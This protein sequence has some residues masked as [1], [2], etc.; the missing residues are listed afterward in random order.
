MQHNAYRI[1]TAEEASSMNVPDVEW[2]IEG[3]LPLGFKAILSG[4]TGSNKSYASM[5]LGMRVASA[6]ED[7]SSEFLSYR[8]PKPLKVLYIDIEVGQDE[9]LRRFQRL[10]KSIEFVR[11]ENFVMISLEG[12][13][14][15]AWSTI[16]DATVKLKP[17]LLIID[18]LYSS[19]DKNMSK[20]QELKPVLKKIDELMAITGTTP[21]LIHHFN[22]ATGE[23]G[24][25]LDR[26]QGA[27]TLQN[28]AEY[29][30]LLSKTNKQDLRLMKVAK[31]RGTHQSEEVYGIRW[32]SE[33]FTLKMEGIIDDYQ[34]YLKSENSIRQ[35]E[36]V[37]DKMEEKFETK[38][39]ER[40]VIGSM[41]LSRETA[42]NWLR[43]VQTIGMIKKVKHGHYIKSGMKIL[44]NVE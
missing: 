23:W 1:I 26:M 13:F 28:W 38:D 10:E 29:I 42:F 37:L 34:K 11:E 17:D 32:D 35:W 39:W 27:S 16:K 41:M 5:E 21:L 25:V 19:T 40:L 18:N 33:T 31:S 36:S 43:E 24:M 7:G 6:N 14:V 9:M 12:S 44:R 8:I 30:I 22:K 3:F 20:Q 15:D 2:I 4:T